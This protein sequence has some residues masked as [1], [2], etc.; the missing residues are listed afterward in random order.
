MVNPAMM[1]LSTKEIKEIEQMAAENAYRFFFCNVDNDDFP[2]DPVNFIY[3]NYDLDDFCYQYEEIN[4]K[5]LV[6]WEPFENYLLQFIVEW[7]ENLIEDN[8]RLAFKAINVI[9]N[10]KG[11]ALVNE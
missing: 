3:D 7:L 11:E 2:E 8:K 4:G 10:K 9:S 6:L 5:R 1:N